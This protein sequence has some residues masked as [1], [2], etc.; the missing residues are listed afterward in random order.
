MRTDWRHLAGPLARRVPAD[1]L[2][3]VLQKNYVSI[4]RIR[5]HV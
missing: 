5:L 3:E 4:Y 2:P 1:Q